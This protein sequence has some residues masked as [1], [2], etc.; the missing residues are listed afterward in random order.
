MI[1]VTTAFPI[2]HSYSW[3]RGVSHPEV[4]KSA[5][6]KNSVKREPLGAADSVRIAASDSK[7]KEGR[8][9]ECRSSLCGARDIAYRCVNRGSGD[10]HDSS[11]R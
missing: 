4:F 5:A 1:S 8:R 6:P 2:L 10:T 7:P 3:P 11:D 9:K